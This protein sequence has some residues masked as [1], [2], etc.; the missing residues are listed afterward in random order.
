MLSFRIMTS[1][2]VPWLKVACHF[3]SYGTA[4]PPSRRGNNRVQ[5]VHTSIDRASTVNCANQMLCCSNSNTTAGEDV[6]VGMLL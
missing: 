6:N 1:P 2:A 5:F 4:T 3:V